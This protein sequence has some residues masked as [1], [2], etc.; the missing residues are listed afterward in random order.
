MDIREWNRR[1]VKAVFH[2]R[3]DIAP[4]IRRIDA[5]DT[6]LA[7]A[8]GF[9]DGAVARESFLA[10]MPHD[11]AGVRGLF[12]Q[13]VLRRWSPLAADL[14]F[15]AQLH[16]TIRAASA[17]E[18]LH[19]EGNFRRRLAQMLGLPMEGDYVSRG[20]L[21]ALWESARRWSNQRAERQHD[22]R[23]L[24][25]PDPGGETIIGH[26]KRLA[27]PNFRDPNRLAEL[28]A[29]AGIDAASPLSHF[30]STVRSRLVGFSER[31][32]EEF[33]R[34][35]SLLERS[36]RAGALDTAFWAA[37][38]ETT[39]VQNRRV[40]HATGAGCRLEIDPTDPYDLGI[41]LYCPATG[42]GGPGWTTCS[43]DSLSGGL[44]RWHRCT[45]P[46]PGGLFDHLRAQWQTFEYRALLGDHA[47]SKGCIGFT[48]DDEGR[49]FDTP[50]LPETG[51]LWL[52]LH[53]DNH[54][55][56]QAPTGHAR[57]VTVYR[58]PLVGSSN[59]TL[60]GPIEVTEEVRRWFETRAFTLDFFLPRLARR[61]VTV[62]DSIRRA[63]GTY[64]YLPPVVPAFRCTDARGGVT[65]VEGAADGTDYPLHLLGDR[66]VLPEAERT[67]SAPDRTLRVV[68]T[69]VSG[70]RVA[71]SLDSQSP[72][73]APSGSEQF[74]CAAAAPN[75]SCGLRRSLAAGSMG[76]EQTRPEDAS[77]VMTQLTLELK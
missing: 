65:T 13:A 40:R 43:Q 75:Q 53:R 37:V 6:F 17:D 63:D 4:E 39:W 10:A 14:P 11:E 26:A 44:I 27:F 31:F 56:L 18:S 45:D 64:L 74:A 69:D 30:V 1:L 67:R 28:F 46:S 77:K 15:Y 60:F 34:F 29:T 5:T 73:F 50:S 20:S 36:D 2:E 33:D 32:R 7:E 52:V 42:D 9:A 71:S 58:A 55:L 21:P 35:C 72:H 19:E 61:C 41:W 38:V 8:S 22:T 24:V 3:V 76:A 51:T 16:L 47:V 48:Q 68:A 23:R 49:W 66:L 54:G 62:V 25:L 57:G 70:N 12:D 59:W